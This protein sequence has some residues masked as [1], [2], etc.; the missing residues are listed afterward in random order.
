MAEALLSVL[1]E[2]LTSLIQKE[3]AILG[4]V[5]KEMEKLSRTLSTICAVLEDAEKKQLTDRAIKNWL[6]KLKDVSFELVDI[7]DECDMEASKLE[8]RMYKSTQSRKVR[9]VSSFIAC[10]NPIVNIVP[11]YRIAKKINE[12]SERF[13]EIG[14]ERMKFHLREAPEERHSQVSNKRETL[15][16]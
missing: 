14:N 16:C 15:F 8:Y 6:R 1:L 4:G 5:N 3:S 13:D 7:L 2:N 11:R 9:A 10:L 12:V